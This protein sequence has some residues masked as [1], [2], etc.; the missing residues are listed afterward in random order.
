[1]P[2]PF[3]RPRHVAPVEVAARGGGGTADG[4]DH[5]VHPDGSRHLEPEDRQGAR[6]LR[7][8]HERPGGTPL[9]PPKPVVHWPDQEPEHLD[10]PLRDRLDRWLTL[11][12]RGQVLE[13]YRVFLG[14][15]QNKTERKEVLAELVFAG[16]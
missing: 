11:V 6:P 9:N 4:T 13:A 2:L 1:R 15:M 5:L 3:E 8:R 7:A 14:L 10:G 16:L 12:H